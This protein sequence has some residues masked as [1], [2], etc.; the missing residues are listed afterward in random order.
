MGDGT[1]INKHEQGILFDALGQPL[2]FDTPATAGGNTAQICDPSCTDFNRARLF[3]W[4]DDTFDTVFLNDG[5]ITSLAL[6][7]GNGDAF[8]RFN[9]EWAFSPLDSISQTPSQS[10]YLISAVP[11][12]PALLLFG[13]GM[14]GLFGMARR[15]ANA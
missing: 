1:T 6:A 7:T 2:R 9:G 8:T 12:P 10:Y 13:S 15:K 11:I 3:F 4:D 14:L 5:T